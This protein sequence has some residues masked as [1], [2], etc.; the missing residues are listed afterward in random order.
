L[1][2]EKGNMQELTETN[3]QQAEEVEVQSNESGQE[4]AASPTKNGNSGARPI[5]IPGQ[6]P[7]PL[8]LKEAKIEVGGQVMS[9]NERQL[10]QLWGLP[11]NEDITDKEFKSLVSAYKA[12]KTADYKS[13]EASKHQ[14][15]V[16]EIAQLIQE[17]PWELLQRAGYNP[18]ELAE[19]YLTQAVEEELLPESE[20]ELRQLRREKEALEKER[21]E[22]LAK[23]EEE[24][25]RIAVEQTKQSISNEIIFALD[26]STLPKTPEVV[27][28]IAGYLYKAELKGIQVNPKQVIPL[29]E[30][31]LKANHSQ[32]LKAMDNQSRLSFLGEDILKE[33]RKEDVA[34]VKQLQSNGQSKP[35]PKTP[36][37]K[38]MTKEE[39]RQE[40]AA[41]IRS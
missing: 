9:I 18:R 10:K 29:V 6:E 37:N 34:R 22:A 35:T 21:Q 7:N 17:N 19:E 26:G 27:S 40:L 41:R 5:V 14:R 12:Q 32:L 2:K 8:G 16:N 30:E 1:I 39:W 33:I 24:Q 25:T 31:D 4:V 3:D 38:K 11:E 23:M 13:I 28:M 20:K 15:I 36:T